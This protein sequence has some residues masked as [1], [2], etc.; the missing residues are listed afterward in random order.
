M[1]QKVGKNRYFAVS[2][3]NKELFGAPVRFLGGKFDGKTGW[4]N[5]NEEETMCYAPVFVYIAATDEVLIDARAYKKNI[6]EGFALKPTSRT[7]AA[8]QQYPR[9]EKLMDK[10]LT[11]LVKCKIGVNESDGLWA[12]LVEKH[13]E[14][15]WHHKVNNPRSPTYY[16]VCFAPSAGGRGRKT[17]R[18]DENVMVTTDN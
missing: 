17:A 4:L 9:I 14:A 7:E 2:D 12:T 8:I 5:T 13:A 6:K 3:V 16:D 1:P 15:L 11:E 10:L 18:D